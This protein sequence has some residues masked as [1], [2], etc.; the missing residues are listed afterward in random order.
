MEVLLLVQLPPL[1]VPVSC[2]KAP[3]HTLRVPLIVGAAVTET[4][5]VVALQPVV[6]SVNVKVTVPAA[7]PV[8]VFPLT[9]A[10]VLSLLVHVPPVAGVKVIVPPTHTV[11][12][13]ALTV[14]L[15]FTVMEE[16][17]ALHPVE[18]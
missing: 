17:V 18:V 12:A 4:E 5:E 8:T 16:V 15:A 7:T 2:E 9:V 14:G 11:D 3:T 13:E 1:G 6:A 10:L